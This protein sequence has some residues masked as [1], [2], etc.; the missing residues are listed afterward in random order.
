MSRTKY[1]VPAVVNTGTARFPDVDLNEPLE[2]FLKRWPRPLPV[3]R[4]PEDDMDGMWSSKSPLPAV[5]DE[6]DVQMNGLGKGTVTGYFFEHGYLGLYVRLS[7][8][9]EWYMKQNRHNLAMIFGAEIDQPTY[10]EVMKNE[11]GV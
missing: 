10:A 3:Y 8:P 5:G 9:P 1:T 2:E 11:R 4:T 6:V 7:S